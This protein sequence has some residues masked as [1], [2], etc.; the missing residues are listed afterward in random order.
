VWEKEPDP[1]NRARQD[2]Q[3]EQPAAEDD[4][5][6]DHHI[7]EVLGTFTAVARMGG[8]APNAEEHRRD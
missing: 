6:L 8:S 7:E 3:F 2:G 5:L 4:R 1:D